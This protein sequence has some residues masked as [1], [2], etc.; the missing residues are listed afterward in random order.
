MSSRTATAGLSIELTQADSLIWINYPWKPSTF[1]QSIDRAHRLDPERNYPGKKLEII[2]LELDLPISIDE[3]KRRVLKRKSILS[4]MI[5]NGNLSPEIISAFIESDLAVIEAIEEGTA[6]PVALD[7][8]ELTI[9]QKF[10]LKIG[11]ILINQDPSKNAEL[12]EEISLMYLEILEHKGSFFANMASLDHLSSDAYPELKTGEPKKVLDLASGPSTLYRAYQRKEGELKKRGLNLDITD[13]DLSPGMLSLGVRRPGAQL[14][15]SFEN[16]HKMPEHSYDIINLS[17]AFRYVSHPALLMQNIYR[18]LKNNGTFIL[19]LPRTNIIPHRFYEALQEA[20]FDLR[21]GKGAQLESKLDAQTYGDLVREYG[22]EFANDIAREAEGKF[23]YL[24]ANKNPERAVK[25]TLDDSDFLLTRE[26]TIIDNDKIEA[27]KHSEG[28]FKIIPYEGSVIGEVH[29]GDERKVTLSAA[30]KHNRTY[31]R[32]IKH[33]S[34]VTQKI[35]MYETGASDKRS[36]EKF[37]K[38]EREMSELLTVIIGEVES[39]GDSYGEKARTTLAQKFDAF[40]KRK[41]VAQWMKKRGGDFIAVV[42]E[43]LHS[44]QAIGAEEQ[45]SNSLMGGGMIPEDLI[46]YARRNT[47]TAEDLVA[48]VRYIGL[49]YQTDIIR[50]ALLDDSVHDP[51]QLAKGDMAKLAKFE[52]LLTQPATETKVLDES[53]GVHVGQDVNIEIQRAVHIMNNIIPAELEKGKVYEVRYDK[54]RLRENAQISV[55]KESPAEALLN[56]YVNCLRMRV[57]EGDPN[58]VIK[59]I[60]HAGNEEKEQSLFSVTCYEDKAKNKVVGKAR[61]NIEGDIKGQPLRVVGMLNMI[62]AASHIPNNT[63]VEELA[64]YEH[65]VSYIQ[66]QYKEITGSDFLPK[67]LWQIVLP[68]I[69]PIPLYEMEQYYRLTII[70][71]QQAA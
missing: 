11:Q 67:N 71:L 70:Q 59:L 41:Y 32:I 19:I 66:S 18:M 22:K 35:T 25:A 69:A 20:G 53:T 55:N 39:Y 8:Y 36:E 14:L 16:L 17:Y 52:E 4:E 3:L 65:L 56:E 31:R 10:R 57:R 43:I 21:V 34:S 23:T 60:D 24:V 54:K 33:F 68:S 49:D 63:P 2:T 1:N 64:K 47:T 37:R 58:E 27:L 50:Q 7:E 12:W 13:Y 48:Y 5:V 9:L 15:G 45:P 46:E 26:R 44:D 40:K 6:S 61:I 38:L 51:S 29:Y 28:K 62:F 30:S 42:E